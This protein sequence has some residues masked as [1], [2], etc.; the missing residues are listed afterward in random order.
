[1]ARP[2]P[3]VR[4]WQRRGAELREEAQGSLFHPGVTGEGKTG[5]VN[6]SEPSMMPRYVD[7]LRWDEDRSTGLA[8]EKRRVPAR[9]SELA[10]RA[11]LPRGREGTH[12]GRVLRARNVETPSGS[13][14][15]PGRLTVRK[16]QL[17]GGTG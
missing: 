17:P 14:L 15:R 7:L 5:R 10:G 2:R 12:P 11:P 1:M 3:D 16:A 6:A 13:R 8:A 4:R 9:D